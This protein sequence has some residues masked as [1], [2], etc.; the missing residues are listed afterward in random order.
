MSSPAVGATNSGVMLGQ[1]KPG[2]DDGA[3]TSIR[4]RAAALGLAVPAAGQAAG[5]YEL[6]RFVADHLHLSGHGPLRDGKPIYRGRVPSDV[7]IEQARAAAQVTA[8]NLLAT[9]AAAVDDDLRKVQGV[10]ALTAYVNADDGFA[11]HPAVVDPASEVLVAVLGVKG[12]HSR[13]SVGVSSLPFGIPIEIS[14]TI[15][16][17]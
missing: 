10:T 16:L 14:L 2:S 4:A 9:I 6:A 7:S 3:V 11:S 13:T 8:L 15:A 17:T 1:V 12:S 5:A